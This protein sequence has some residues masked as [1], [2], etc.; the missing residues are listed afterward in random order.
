M[1]QT[2]N[3]LLFA[4]WPLPPEVLQRLIPDGLEVDTFGGEAWIAVTP[5]VLTGLR[6]RAVPA[7]PGVSTFP[8]VNVRTYVTAGGKPGVW[9]FSLDAGSRLAVAGARLLY[10]LPY[11]HA[12]F[13]I[14]VE[15]QWIAYQS[16]RSTAGSIPAELSVT[17]RPTEEARVAPPG[18]LVAWL[19]ERY[20]LYAADRAR[21]LY[22]AEIHHAPW[23][24][25][26]A[27]ARLER[28]TMTAPLGV[29]LP[30]VGPLLHFAKRLDVHV[31][32]PERV[33]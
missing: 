12:A 2:W 15:R 28:N 25:C 6:P 19:T 24:L 20:C 1:A 13:S 11:H 17:Y 8:E 23:P 31:W 3:D 10:S 32:G 29:A 26:A 7:V 9:F 21:R 30:D 27:T 18:S 33:R 22:R 4:H 16:R 14:G 5:F